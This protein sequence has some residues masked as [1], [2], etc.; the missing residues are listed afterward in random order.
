MAGPLKQLMALLSLKKKLAITSW[1]KPCTV[2]TY[3]FSRIWLDHET[4]RLL[5]LLQM[6]LKINIVWFILTLLKK[7]EDKRYENGSKNKHIFL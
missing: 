5:I 4:L 6:F 1:I 7:F 2:S 3:F